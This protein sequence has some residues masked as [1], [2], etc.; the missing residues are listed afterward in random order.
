M[1]RQE[2]RQI[3]F[4]ALLVALSLVLLHIAVLLPSGRLGMTAIAGLV[5][6]AAVV[7]YGLPSG[8]QCYI[9]TAIMAFILIP[10][11]GLTTLYC[12]FLGL[13]P[14]VKGGVERLRRL[15]LEIFLKLLFFNGILTLL[16]FF[17]KQIL[18]AAVPLESTPQWL[19]YLGGNGIFLVYDF[20]I[21]QVIAVCGKRILPLLRKR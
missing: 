11:K 18:Y 9:C 16:L 20:G 21:S 6:V 14:I 10:D 13:Y 15:P 2:T 8:V 17:M 1:K 4:R 3:A 12:L 5:P 19:V 7:S